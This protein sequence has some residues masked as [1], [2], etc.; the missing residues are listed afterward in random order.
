VKQVL[1]RGGGVAVEDVPAPQ[2]SPRSVLVR[3]EH[4]CVSVGTEMSSV[5]MSGL[6]L[7]KRALKQPHH[8]KR[9]LEIARDEGFARTY[10][11]VR[12]M[13]SAGL[14][15]GYS[16]AGT[17]VQIGAE[18]EGF[19]V[20]D[21]VACAGAGIAN[22]AELIDVPVNLAV[23]IPDGLDTGAA[24]TVTLGAIA[25]QGV[26]RVQP[27]LGETV[28]LMGLGI[29]GQ[30]A[31]QLLRASGA[32]VVGSDLDPSRVEKALV[33]GMAHGLGAG[34][35]FPTRVRELT[36]GF[37]AD[38]VLITA[39]TESDEVVRQAMQACRKKGRVVLVGDVGLHLQ[40]ADMYEKEL[41]FL[42][43]TSY[44]PGRYDDVYELEGQDYPIGYVRWTENRNMEEYLRLLAEGRVSLEGLGQETFPVDEADTAYET[45]KSGAKKP[46][47]VLLSYPTRDDAPSQTKRLRA[48]A[49]TPGRLG[50]ALVGAGA[51]AQAQHLP[52]LIKLREQFELRAVMSRTGATA[53]A[54]A[55]RA[56]AA[57]ATTDLD[58]V[59]GDDAIDLV[60]ISTRHDSHAELTLRALEAGKNV[61]VEKPLALTEEELDAIAA[62]YADRDAPLLQ[63]G[64]NRRFSPVVTR[65]RELLAGRT[66]PLVA[67]YRMNAGYIPLGHWV[68]G[69]EG[70]GRNIGEACHVYDVFDTL[71][72][73]EETSVQAQTIGA[74]SRNWAA[75][76]NFVA[77]IGY[78]D[79]SVCTLTYT[80]LGH[81]D[82][83]K[84][85]LDVYAGGRVYSL[86]DYKSLSVAGG[87]GGWRSTTVRKG[88]VEE[89]QA[90]ARALREGGPWPISLEQQLQATRI[91]FAV[92]R[93]LRNGS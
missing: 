42:I 59:L 91:S 27:T 18:V 61:F 64:F 67:N 10:K 3:V 78:A 15:T 54:V 76:D 53:K 22:H 51:F 26:R 34:E 48:L 72:A 75:N 17:V 35:D 31:V 90:L 81:R 44:G 8:A 58:A 25:L 88:H 87:D 84:E 82:H 23:R 85:R 69:P 86:D 63:T 43:S 2:A 49:P 71:V 74:V 39:A 62:F 73:A 93:Q 50:V 45:L 21:R 66:S 41:D 89:L 56:E 11:R 40:R 55:A 68:H 60:L 80:A 13:L 9:V 77:T 1:I 20:G 46:L 19:R 12:G 5:R 37:G 24:S 65:L 38:A 83:P 92:E 30:L 4:S 6:P 36:D 29:L 57:Y 32:R 16:A 28:A 7:Y 14:P 33:H 52:N 70:G 47:L 79:G